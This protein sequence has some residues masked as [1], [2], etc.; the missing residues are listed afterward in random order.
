[1]SIDYAKSK[2]LYTKHKGAL[3]RAKK[4][5]PE[6]VIKECEAFVRDFEDLPWPDSWHT[7]NIAYG[8]AQLALGKGFGHHLDDIR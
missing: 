7:W 8:D 6:A 4:K 2:R 1:M 5:G 3:T